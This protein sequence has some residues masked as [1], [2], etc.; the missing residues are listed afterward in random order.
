MNMRARNFRSI[1]QALH[2]INHNASR[3]S[4]PRYIGSSARVA[5]SKF[6]E[7]VA[8]RRVEITAGSFI[9]ALYG[10][11]EDVDMMLTP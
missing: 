4:S 10:E 7:A 8:A 2:Y 11:P 9:L 6:R 1:S 3:I 5:R